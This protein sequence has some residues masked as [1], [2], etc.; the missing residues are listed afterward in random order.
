MLVTLGGRRLA[1]DG[2]PFIDSRHARRLLVLSATLTAAVVV[3][4]L[5]YATPSRADVV[6]SGNTATSHCLEKTATPDPVKVGE[7]LTF[8]VRGYCTA[9]INCFSS[10][11]PGMTDT[12]PAGLEF[13]SASATGLDDPT[14][15]FSESNRTVTCAPLAYFFVRDGAEVPFVATIKVIPRECGTFTNTASYVDENSPQSVS[16]TFTVEGCPDTTDPTLSVSHTGANADNWNNTSPVTVNISASDSTGSGLAGAPTCTDGTTD[17]T[18][19]AG[20]TAGNWTAS[21][22]GEGTHTISCSVT[23]KAGNQTSTS[24]TVMIDTT[25]P[26]LT[27]GHTGANANGWN[28]TSPVTVNVSDSDSGSGL[29]GDPTCTDG[30]ISLTL[31]AGSTAGTWTT[32]VSGDGTHTI[33][34]SVTD[35]AGNQTTASDTVM[36]DTTAPSVTCSVTPD[37]L[38]TSANNHKLVSIKATVTVTD[39]GGSGDGGFTLLSVTSNQPQSGLARDDVA[40]DTQ[41]WSTGTADTNG[42]LR[43][44]RY[45][46]ARTYTLTYQGKDLAGNTKNCSATVTVPKGR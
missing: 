2:V 7:T 32:S 19:T 41:G 30:T 26:T 4:L 33:S 25:D 21:V 46:G 40:N 43:A 20:S 12:L 3:G 35:K 28:N 29:A 36:I 22:S 11:T 9:T 10:S 17:L 38:S 31:T 18:L 34:C 24:D 37:T 14:C 39:S 16:E 13:V 8:T 42:Q 45:G 5:G 27:V 44:E 23:D 6:C 1:A 15:T